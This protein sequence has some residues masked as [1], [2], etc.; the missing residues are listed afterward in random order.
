MPARATTAHYRD[1]YSGLQLIKRRGRHGLGTGNARDADP[2][3]QCKG[4]KPDHFFSS[5]GSRYL[6]LVAPLKVF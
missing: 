3:E 5:Y 6:D 1:G 4:R 2:D